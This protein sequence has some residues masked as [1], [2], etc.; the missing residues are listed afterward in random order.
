MKSIFE[1]RFSNFRFPISIFLSRYGRLLV[2]L[3]MAAIALALPV[4]LAAQ[5]CAM[6]YTSAAAAKK[7]GLQALQSGILILGIPPLVMFIGIFLYVFRRRDRF[8]DATFDDDRGRDEMPSAPPPTL[9]GELGEEPEEVLAVASWSGGRDQRENSI[10][11]RQ[12][13]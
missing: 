8:N 12:G 5:G 1:F 6:C 3:A 2:L 11:S 10:S 4:P 9:P 13:H 7:A